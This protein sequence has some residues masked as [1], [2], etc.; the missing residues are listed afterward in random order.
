MPKSYS[1][2]LRKR[3]IEAV[4]SG[5]SRHEAA[6]LFGIAVSTAVK[7]W[8]HWRETGS[9]APKPRGGSKSR[10]EEH[11]ISILRL[12][13]EQPDSTFE[14]LLAALRKRRI[15][16]SRS[17]LWRFFE[18][19]NIT[20][21]KS[22]RAAERQQAD[23][24]R[25][26]RRWIREQGLLDPAHLV[27]IDETA[28]STN[29]VRLYGRGPRGERVIDDVPQGTWKTITFVAAL[30]HHKMVAPMVFDG[31]MTGQMFL[32]YVEHCLAPTLKRNDIVVIDNL[33]AHKVVGV[34]EAIETAGATLRHLPQYSPDLNPIEMPY[35][36]SK[37]S[38]TRSPPGPSQ[39]CVEPFAPS[40][41]VSALASGPTISGIQD[42]F[43]YDRNPL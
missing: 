4:A 16:S 38:C 23:V 35:S 15:R 36:N 5:V 10:L 25:A 3:V 11:R 24:A 9:T 32:A 13:K 12:V 21:K 39:R 33:R 43:P 29:M 41:P 34:R 17:A 40:S 14:E 19:H 20:F 26:R 6:E 42:M 22:L 8:Q 30:R 1:A 2:D 37:L 31:P 18:R 7:W 27:F 28:V